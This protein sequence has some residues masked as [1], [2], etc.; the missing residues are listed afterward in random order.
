MHKNLQSAIKLKLW[1]LSM[2]QQLIDFNERQKSAEGDV[3]VV[4]P[5]MFELLSAVQ[6]LLV[7]QLQ[8]WMSTT[9]YM[10]L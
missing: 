6:D 7:E 4:D 8:Q 10:C 1:T 3:F 5:W 2:L 9:V